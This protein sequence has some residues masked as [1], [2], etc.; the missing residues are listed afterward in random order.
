[1]KVEFIVAAP[2]VL[3]TVQ[4][5]RWVTCTIS[6]KKVS[7]FEKQDVFDPNGTPTLTGEYEIFCTLDDEEEAKGYRTR[8]QEQSPSLYPRVI[9]G[10]PVGRD[11]VL[12]KFKSLDLAV[13]AIEIAG[14][15]GVAKE[16]KAELAGVK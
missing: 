3:P 14:K 16:A 13:H 7:F 15:K 2:G 9:F 12:G 1:M 10:K 6:N 4:V 11:V 5:E 8:L